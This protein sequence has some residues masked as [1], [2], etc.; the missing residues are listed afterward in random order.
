MVILVLILHVRSLLK[1]LF[2][3]KTRLIVAFRLSIITH[4][5]SEILT[6]TTSCKDTFDRTKLVE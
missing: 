5:L 3:S 4:R 1:P 6:E 2:R